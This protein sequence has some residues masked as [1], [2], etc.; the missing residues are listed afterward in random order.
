[1]TNLFLFGSFGFFEGAARVMDLGATMVVYNDSPTTE[2]ADIRALDSDWRAVG[3]DI[4]NAM[5]SYAEKEK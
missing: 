2:E 4:K 1:M 3:D 5:T